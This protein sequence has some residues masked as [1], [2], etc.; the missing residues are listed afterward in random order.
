MSA[1]AAAFTTVTTLPVCGAIA[2][3]YAHAAVA[4]TAT[5]KGEKNKGK[6]DLLKS[7]YLGHAF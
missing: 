4:P 5:N 6:N 1:T 3:S 2:H 7:Y